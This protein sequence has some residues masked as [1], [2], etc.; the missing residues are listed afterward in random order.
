[1]GFIAGI[2][3]DRRDKPGGDEEGMVP[4]KRHPP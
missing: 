1:M 3:V 4:P 2:H